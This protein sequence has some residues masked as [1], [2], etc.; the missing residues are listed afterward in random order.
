MS[1]PQEQERARSPGQ[2][3]VKKPN[4]EKFDKKKAKLRSLP[5]SK[6]MSNGFIK[7]YDKNGAGEDWEHRK[8]RSCTDVPFLV[9]FLVFVL[10]LIGVG[11][12]AYSNGD[13]SRMQYGT[14]MNG[15]RCG[16]K[17]SENIHIPEDKA[18]DL[19]DKPYLYW[20]TPFDTDIQICVEECPKENFNPLADVS[21]IS[22][23]NMVCRYGIDKPDS[24][25]LFLGNCWPV[26]KS[27]SI[28]RRCIPT[29]AIDLAYATNITGKNGTEEEDF[30][31]EKLD[32]STQMMNIVMADMIEAWPVILGCVVFAV[33]LG[34]FWLLFL[35][36]FTA[37]MVW[38]TIFCAYGTMIV[39]TSYGFYQVAKMKE[40]Y[41]DTPEAER[42][43]DMERN[44]I[45]AEVFTW[46]LLGFTLIMLILVIWL[47]RRIS[48]AIGIMEQATVAIARMP[49][50]IVFP[51]VVFLLQGCWTLWYMF[52]SAYLS[53]ASAP[54]FTGENKTFS[55][56]EDDSDV[57]RALH[58]Y[59]FFGF[60]WVEQFIIAYGEL[61]IAG[62]IAIWYW[63]HEDHSGHRHVG[64]API[65]WSAWMTFRYHLGTVA[66]GSLILAIVKFVRELLKWFTNRL[67]GAESGPLKQML[68]CCNCLLL[69]FEKFIKFINRNAYIMCAI[70][71]DNFC[72]S[73]KRAFQLLLANVL[74]VGAVNVI[75]DFMMFLGKVFI[76]LFTTLLAC[77]I[78]SDM[79]DVQYW[80]IPALFICLISFFVAKSFM[81]VYDMAVDTILLSFCE[82]VE[83]NDGT[84][85]R[86]YFMPDSLLKFVDNSHLSKWCGC[87]C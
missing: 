15:N 32:D 3:A 33:V 5:S 8:H 66:F 44:I 34:F 52:T 22:I 50:I 68:R 80:A 84:R 13:P 71:G 56:Y 10:G 23:K 72:N 87:S 40:T 70:R 60:L 39:A 9:L 25:Q 59:N 53:T 45:T 55:G 74:R 24:T 19:T 20:P 57:V 14:D 37:I 48:L 51:A 38:A 31:N 42:T 76:T 29:A 49:S 46:V 26:Y 78:L 2:A 47:R 85:E 7:V 83:S 16:H 79:D 17:N 21:L 6:M 1:T 81:N 41:D 4:K 12:E 18:E 27:K 30:Q 11:Y 77:W 69:C 61:S 65:A 35:R 75:G 73:A 43:D 82:D 64:R 58:F 62:A 36:L 86:P 28:L 54:E 63:Q 67:K